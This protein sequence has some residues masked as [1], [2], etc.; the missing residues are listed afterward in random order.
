MYASLHLTS[1]KL[2]LHPIG[3]FLKWLGIFIIWYFEQLGQFS[4][5]IMA[6]TSPMLQPFRLILAKY[7]QIFKIAQL[8]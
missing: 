8:T 4:G 1:L 7:R 6:K 3:P 2:T 5:P